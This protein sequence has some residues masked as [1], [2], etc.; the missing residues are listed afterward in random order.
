VLEEKC[1]NQYFNAMDGG[2]LSW[3][4][5]FNELR[6]WFG[7]ERVQGP[8]E[9]ASKLFAIKLAGGKEAPLGYGPPVALNVSSTL[10][11]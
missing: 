5:F 3:D 2:T 1:K 6:R 4:R 10:M 11:Q 8:E 9:D 7:V